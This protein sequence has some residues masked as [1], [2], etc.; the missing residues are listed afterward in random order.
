MCYPVD[1]EAQ[2]GTLYSVS[3]EGT[4]VTLYPLADN[5]AVAGQPVVYINGDTEDYATPVEDKEAEDYNGNLRE[6]TTFVHGTDFVSQAGV[7]GALT[8]T[9]ADINIGAGNIVAQKNGLWVTK[10]SSN[11][12]KANT[13][14]IA[15]GI[16]DVETEVTLVIGT[17]SDAIS[18]VLSQVSKSGNIYTVGGQMV[19]RGNLNSLKSMPRGMYII[20]G[21]KVMVK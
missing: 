13:A 21:V 18:E 3:V 10:K 5:K 1:I 12:V 4:T 16:E 20:N 6:L 2:N 14:Y 11:A 8:G 17:E 9:F 7:S 19:G 15:A